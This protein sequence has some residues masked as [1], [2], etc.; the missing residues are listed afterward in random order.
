MPSIYL[1]TLLT[2][3][4]AILNRNNG[5][6]YVFMRYSNRIMGKNRKLTLFLLAHPLDE[7]MF[8]THSLYGSMFCTH[9][10]RRINVW[11]MAS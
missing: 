4:F 9:P 10:A 1:I 3:D 11:A 8:C 7:P 5:I 6:K 2:Q